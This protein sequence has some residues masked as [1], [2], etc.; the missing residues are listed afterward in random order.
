[1]HR[2]FKWVPRQV[3]GR[4]RLP[5]HEALSHD[6]QKHAEVER[7]A[8]PALLTWHVCKVHGPAAL[9]ESLAIIAVVSRAGG[10]AWYT[11]AGTQQ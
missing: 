7:L 11:D 5:V 1:M 2:A 4:Q 10:L 8:A 3:V 9:A 6:C